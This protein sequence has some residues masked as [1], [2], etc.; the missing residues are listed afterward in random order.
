MTVF[1]TLYT[2]STLLIYLNV[3]LGFIYGVMKRGRPGQ[4]TDESGGEE[5]RRTLTLGEIE[6]V[7]QNSSFS[8]I[9]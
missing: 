9:L 2:T 5:N 7:A 1:T 4:L 8:Q 3:K 6:S